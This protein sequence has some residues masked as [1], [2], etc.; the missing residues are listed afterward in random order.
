M[1][2][3]VFLEYLGTI[4]GL[5]YIIFMIREHIA[6]WG[7][8][9]I[10]SFISIYIFIQTKLYSEA[11]LNVYYIIIGV[12]G[13]WAWS[14]MKQKATFDVKRWPYYAHAIILSV[15]AT[16]SAG[17]GYIFQTYTDANNPY[18]DASTTIFS[19]IASYLEARKVL[20]GWVY[21]FI[22]NG[23]SIYLYHL[24]GLDV[25]AAHS[26]VYTALSLVGFIRWLK[27]YRSYT[28]VAPQLS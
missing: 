26:V 13:W 28:K 14:Q 10:G 9:I 15:G 16:L 5:L 6:C 25:Y 22:I 7:L 4:F 2:S 11:L 3:L 17:L 1:P 8:G 12:Y 19:F 21:W 23:F 24:R 27:Q 20:S 18:E